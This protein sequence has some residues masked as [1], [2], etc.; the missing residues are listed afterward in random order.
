MS[1]QSRVITGYDCEFLIGGNYFARIFGSLYRSGRLLDRETLDNPITQ[2]FLSA[3]GVHIEGYSIKLKGTISKQCFSGIE[4]MDE[5]K[6]RALYQFM[7]QRGWLSSETLIQDFDPD[8]ATLQAYLSAFL[9][10]ASQAIVDHLRL[11]MRTVDLTI[12]EPYRTVLFDDELSVRTLATSV[13]MPIAEYDLTRFMTYLHDLGYLNAD[14]RLNVDVASIRARIAEWLNQAMP[15]HTLS[16]INA[17]RAAQDS[18]DTLAESLTQALI[19]MT[20]AKLQAMLD[21][22]KEQKWLTTGGRLSQDIEDIEDT[23]RPWLDTELPSLADAILTVLGEPPELEIHIPVSLAGMHTFANGDARYIGEEVNEIV[24]FVPCRIDAKAIRLGKSVISHESIGVMNHF[25]VLVEKKDLGAGL[26]GFISDLIPKSFQLGLV[27]S[28]SVHHIDY[29]KLAGGHGFTPAWGIYCNVKLDLRALPVDFDMEHYNKPGN[30]IGERV[31]VAPEGHLVVRDENGEVIDAQRFVYSADDPA[32]H[33]DTLLYYVMGNASLRAITLDEVGHIVVETQNGWRP[34][35]AEIV[36]LSKKN[37]PRGDLRKTTNFLREGEDFAI[38]I[39]ESILRRYEKSLWNSFYE[40]WPVESSLFGPIWFRPMRDAYGRQIG[41]FDDIDFEWHEGAIKC[42][43]KGEYFVELF[44]IPDA[45]VTCRLAIRPVINDYKLTLDVDVEELSADTGLLGDLVVFILGTLAFGP[46]G[47]VFGVPALEI[48]EDYLASAQE[49]QVLAGVNDKTTQLF[50]TIPSVIELFT[51]PGDDFAYTI[52]Y[53][54]S[55]LY[56]IASVNTE[57]LLLSG[58]GG[59]GEVNH[60]ANVLLTGRTR[61][62]LTWD[63]F[64][65]IYG[66]G[67]DKTLNVTPA[68]AKFRV[69]TRSLMKVTLTPNA[70]YTKDGRIHSLRFDSGLDLRVEEIIQLMRDGVVVVP[71]VKIHVTK[72]GHEYLRSLPDHTKGNNLSELPTFKPADLP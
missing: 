30:V 54:P 41:E 24:L 5:A 44:L 68:Y 10:D 59:I 62:P 48:A 2:A 26:S 1:D 8:N 72:T 37:L 23:L 11:A 63:L 60:P 71:R 69:R 16:V 27:P 12:G 55:Q 42:V 19:P 66:D 34:T 7:T 22:M 17:V 38:G 32:T 14:G 31:E 33:S 20:E 25:G 39:G 43:V 35:P 56:E 6:S 57:G 9:P 46:Y 51:K 67:G 18:S 52:A 40:P 29:K 15:T 28:D 13:F 61:D 50:T 58:K 53:G 45:D 64:E 4:G 49:D 47:L 65:L 70:R 21:F 3:Y 36:E